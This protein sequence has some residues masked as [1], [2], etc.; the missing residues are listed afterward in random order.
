MFAYRIPD[1]QP[2]TRRRRMRLIGEDGR[3]EKERE[4]K[5]MREYDER[6]EQGR[7][8]MQQGDINVC[9][10]VYVQRRCDGVGVLLIPR[11]RIY[12]IEG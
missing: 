11:I 2:K 10:C 3:V 9:V 4:T 5:R 7:N 1:F 12:I 6:G 8:K